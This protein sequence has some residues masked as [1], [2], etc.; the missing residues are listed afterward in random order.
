MSERTCRRC[1]APLA[2]DARFCSNCGMPV[3]TAAAEE[4]KLVSVLFADVAGSTEL[5]ARLDAE[6]FREV[7]GAVYRMASDEVASLRGRTEKFIGDAIMAVFGLPHAHEDDALRAVRAGLR[8]RDRV[9]HLGE[10]LALGSP[11]RVRVGVNTGPVVASTATSGEFLVS[12]P[13]VNA[14]ARLEQAATP[15]EVL[16]G[17]MTWQLTRDSAE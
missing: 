16:V 10:E 13:A 9:E 8:I 11:L 1:G 12:G 5:A 17:D 15:G 4:R 3:E 14:A 7:M 2:S 6:R